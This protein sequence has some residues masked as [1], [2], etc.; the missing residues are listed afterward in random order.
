M[1]TSKLKFLRK[2]ILKLTQQEF[3]D[4][5]GAFQHQV[6]QWENGCSTPNLPSIKRINAAFGEDM[7]H[8]GMDVFNKFDFGSL[9]ALEIS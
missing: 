6:S 7:K 5:V 1:H 8:Y 9:E 4:K 2:D 3:A